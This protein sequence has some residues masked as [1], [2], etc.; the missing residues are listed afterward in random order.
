MENEIQPIFDGELSIKDGFLPTF[1][2]VK[3]VGNFNTVLL[4]DTSYSMEYDVAGRRKIDSLRDAVANLP[5]SLR[6]FHFGCVCEEC[7]ATIPEPSGSTAMVPA[8]QKIKQSGANHIIMVTDGQPNES[9]AVV[10]E[11]ARGLTIDAIFIGDPSD[12]SAKEF[13][14]S[15]T[16]ATGGRYGENTMDVDGVRELENNIIRLLEE[17]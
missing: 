13:L 7:G 11:E 2:D 3:S 9:Y 1:D 14:K 17:K 10:I 8:L 6:R 12:L 16:A 4:L 5:L 15:L